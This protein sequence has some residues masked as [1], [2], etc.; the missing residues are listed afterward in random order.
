MLTADSPYNRSGLLTL[1][2]EFFEDRGYLAVIMS[3][4]RRGGTR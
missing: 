1:D 4:E 3:R 2:G